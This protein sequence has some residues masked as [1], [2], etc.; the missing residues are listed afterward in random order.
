MGILAGKLL[1]SATWWRV[2]GGDGFGGDQF[3]TPVLVKCRWEN[4]QETYIGQIDRRELI[5]KAV[6]YLDTDVSVG[7]YLAPGDLTATSSPVGVATAYKVQRYSKTPNLRNL[8]YVR[9]V[10]L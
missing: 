1:E 7:D 2:T 9:K 4:K 10:I 6:V 5:S 8:D 3:A